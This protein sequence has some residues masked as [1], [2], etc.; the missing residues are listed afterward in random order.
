MAFRYIGDAVDVPGKRRQSASR[1]LSLLGVIL[2]NP[3]SLL[4][5]SMLQSDRIRC[6]D[7]GSH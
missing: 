7:P 2:V 6:I 4:L 5:G 3:I 1:V